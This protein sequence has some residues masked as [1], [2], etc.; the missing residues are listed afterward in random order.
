MALTV[1]WLPF[2]TIS[3]LRATTRTHSPTGSIRNRL[4]C[5]RRAGL[6]LF[7]KDSGKSQRRAVEL[8]SPPK[9]ALAAFE[10]A[11]HA[12]GAPQIV[13]VGPVPRVASG[14]EVSRAQSCSGRVHGCR[15]GLVR[16]R[17]GARKPSRACCR[18]RQPDGHTGPA[19]IGLWT[20]GRSGQWVLSKV[21]GEGVGVQVLR[22]P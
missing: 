15:P 12:P 21:V 22:A 5:L 17:L 19:L 4:P 1:K 13:A 2:A 7:P 20:F 16:T 9:Q 8:P 10:P 14:E 3:R 11:R 6:S 18:L